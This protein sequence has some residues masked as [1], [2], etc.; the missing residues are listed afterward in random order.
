MS[1]VK[2]KDKYQVTLPAE[3]RKQVGLAVGDLLEVEIKGAQI[4]LT[5]KSVV[6][7]ELDLAL[8]DYEEGLSI[9]PFE[10]TEAAVR[11][12]RSAAK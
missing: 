1:L 2:V 6:D 12:L 9:G 3:I 11:A 7:R 5:P 8:E 4:T 10:T